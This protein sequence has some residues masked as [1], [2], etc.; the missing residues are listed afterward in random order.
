MWR[1]SYEDEKFV[2]NV[3]KMWS[4][5]E[6]LYNELHTYV[7]R[8]LQKIYDKQMDK[9]S[10]L[11]PAHLLGNMWAQSWVNLYDRLKP[12]KDGSLIDITKK[13]NESMSVL[14]MFKESNRFYKALGLEGNEMSYDESLGP[15]VHKPKDRVITCHASAWDFCDKTDFRIKMCTNIDQEDFVT[16]SF[17]RDWRD[18][19]SMSRSS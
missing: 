11:I 4:Q 6:P 3:D 16:V 17:R 5:V 12:F 10:D 2:E 13:L 19:S 9:D 15:V 18:F 1:E 8:K 14:D 7:R